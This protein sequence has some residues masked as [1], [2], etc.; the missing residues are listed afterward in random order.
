M[1]NLKILE[2]SKLIQKFGGERLV[3][4]FKQVKTI[5]CSQQTKVYR[6]RWLRIAIMMKAG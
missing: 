2:N 4:E 6:M 3:A 5:I 1:I